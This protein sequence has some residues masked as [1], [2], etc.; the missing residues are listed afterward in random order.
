MSF[1]IMSN[2]RFGDCQYT[3]LLLSAH[4]N[5]TLHALVQKTF[6]KQIHFAGLLYKQKC[7]QP[8]TP[9]GR[10]VMG[11]FNF[12]PKATAHSRIQNAMGINLLWEF[13]SQTNPSMNT[14]DA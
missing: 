12:L 4:L 7:L 6:A 8:W 2:L 13:A 9:F 10:Q 14:P 1:I 11:C 5:S 3:F